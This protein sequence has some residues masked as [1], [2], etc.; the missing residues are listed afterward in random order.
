MGCQNRHHREFGAEGRNGQTPNPKQEFSKVYG[1]A[2]IFNILYLLAN[3]KNCVINPNPDSSEFI[4]LILNLDRFNA[5]VSSNV[6]GISTAERDTMGV[7]T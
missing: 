4:C 7:V 3:Y 6:E 5:D 1:V 2:G